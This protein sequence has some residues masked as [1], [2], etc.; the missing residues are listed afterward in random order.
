[1]AYGG[2]GIVVGLVIWGRRVI[3]T[4]GA[5]LTMITPSTGFIIE[6]GASMTILVAS[7]AGIPVSTTQCIVGAVMAVG[8]R[9]NEGIVS[10]TLFGFIIFSWILTIPS[11]GNYFLFFHL[12]ALRNPCSFL[13]SFSRGW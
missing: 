6:F 12:F 3:E 2:L 11:V 8:Y 1:L 10:W 7:V 4:L 9:S 5:R 13:F